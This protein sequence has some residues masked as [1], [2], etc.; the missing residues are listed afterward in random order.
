MK[1][2]SIKKAKVVTTKVKKINKAMM[3]KVKGGTG[4]AEF[5]K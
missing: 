1:S 4:E 3:Q 2:N 5:D